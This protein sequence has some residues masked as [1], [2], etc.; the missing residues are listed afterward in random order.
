MRVF[1]NMVLSI[2]FGPKRDEATRE[3]R[4]LC[5][6]L[7]DLCSSSR[8]GHVARMGRGEMHRVMEEKCKGKNHLQNLV[9][10]ERILKWVSKKWNGGSYAQGC[11]G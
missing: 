11:S 8:V 5:N 7:Y 10:D 4:I 2:M 9:V 6:E 1:E 3:W